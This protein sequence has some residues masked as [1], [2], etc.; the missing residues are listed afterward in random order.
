MK[1][2][3]SMKI[4]VIC[5]L[6]FLG[7]TTAVQ[8][9]DFDYGYDKEEATKFI[10]KAAQD[11]ASVSVTGDP[12]PLETI[13]AD[14]FE[15]IDSNGRFYTK[16][17]FIDYIKTG[18]KKLDYNNVNQDVF[19]I[20]F[21]GNVAITQ[22]YEDWAIDGQEMRFYWTDVYAYRDNRWQLVSAQD[23]TTDRSEDAKPE[24]ALFGIE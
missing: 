7:T 3:K 21:Y 11:W 18:P 13:F 15:G 5:V 20:R 23:M 2:C 9:K 12:T 4:L 1:T 16:R 17:S 24:A 22:A 10:R 6:S 19:R 14:D 8:A